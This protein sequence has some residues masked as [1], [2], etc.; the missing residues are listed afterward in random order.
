MMSTYGT[1]RTDNG[2]EPGGTELGS[3]APRVLGLVGLLFLAGLGVGALVSTM[4]GENGGE[5]IVGRDGSI[6][7]AAPA[8]AAD[9]FR[10]QTLP[11]PSPQT[12]TQP[13]I[14]RSRLTPTVIAARAVGP[15]VVSIRVQRAG[16]QTRID[17]LLGRGVRPQ[18]NLGSGFAVDAQGH[19]L[20]NQHVVRG[21]ARIEVIDGSG[22]RLP[23]ELVGA[24]E[25]S[26]LAVLRIEAGVVPVA[27]LGNSSDLFVG[28]PAIA[29]GNPS[30]YQLANTEPTV[31]TGVVSGIGRDIVSAGQ[32][33]LY[34]DMIQ[35]DAAINP[36][37]S[38]GP[39]VN[40]DGRVIGVNSSIFSLSGGSEGLGFA[41]PI[42]RA[43]RL[44]A[45]LIEVGRVRRPWVGLDVVTAP[46]DEYLRVPLVARVHEGTPGARAGLQRGDILLRLNGRTISHDLDWDIALVDV[47]VNQVAEV[48]YR[49]G[50]QTFTTQLSLEEI[51]S[52]RAE[53]VEVLSGLQL[54]SVTP[55]IQQEQALAIEFGAMIVDIDPAVARTTRLQEGDV[56]FG[57]NRTQ[58]N[59]AEEAGELFGY[60]GT[61]GETD[62]WVRVHFVRGKQRGSF[63]FRV[64]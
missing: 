28:E 39:L 24:D 49:R 3:T 40:A 50:N 51:P 1:A 55:R 59:T 42:N 60:Y 43:L 53:R 61:S 22:R 19:V 38:G 2:T 21:A 35:T 29:I 33:V 48:E 8:E 56:I 25:I 17:Q 13:E 41:I 4:R 16:R 10:T 54:I 12:A 14:S 27:P 32:D 7:T 64:G 23:A 20:T 58:V 44:A 11:T 6:L 37:N 63:D 31:T 36:G 18:S 62:G 34:A 57:I 15:S 46:S 52:A 47:G 9:R 5:P 26:D 30:G 45:E